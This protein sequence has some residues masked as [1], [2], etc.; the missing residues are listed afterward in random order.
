MKPAIAD[1]NLHDRVGNLI[2]RIATTFIEGE[3]L[4][5]KFAPSL[6][7]SLHK[8]LFNEFEYATNNQLFVEIDR[9]EKEI[10]EI[11]FFL[12]GPSPQMGRIEIADLQIMGTDVSFR[13][14]NQAPLTGESIAQFL[15]K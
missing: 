7:F 11:G 12:I 6:H 3:L 8:K 15:Q 13:L 2:G 1:F 10:K 9:L 5:G 14:K 4:L